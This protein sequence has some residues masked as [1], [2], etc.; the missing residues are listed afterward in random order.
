MLVY[1]DLLGMMQHPHH[2]KVT[3]KFCKQYAAVGSAIQEALQQYRAE[4]GP[5]CKAGVQLL[6]RSPSV[7]SSLHPHTTPAPK[8]D[9]HSFDATGLHA[10]VGRTWLMPAKSQCS[11]GYLHELHESQWL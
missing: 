10:C 6:P 11:R 1:H 4:V 5:P 9:W 2:A 8:S 3:P 7:S